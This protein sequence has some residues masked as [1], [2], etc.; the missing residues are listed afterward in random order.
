MVQS[1]ST[2]SGTVVNIKMDS[3]CDDHNT[4]PGTKNT[5]NSSIYYFILNHICVHVCTLKDEDGKQVDISVPCPLS[6]GGFLGFFSF[7]FFFIP[8]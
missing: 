2:T 1:N 4:V 3:I 8:I 7:L 6:N 5:I